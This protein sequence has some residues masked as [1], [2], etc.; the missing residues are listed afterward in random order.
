MGLPQTKN[1]LLAKEPPARQKRHPT[2]WEKIFANTTSD[3][4]QIIEIYKE[5]IQ[6]NTKQTIQLKYG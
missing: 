6:R 1:L 3:K 4:G 5:L 2:K